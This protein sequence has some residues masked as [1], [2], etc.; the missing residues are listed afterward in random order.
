M[1]KFFLLLG[2]PRCGSSCATACFSF[3][4][5]SLGPGLSLHT[6][7]H[8]EKGYFENDRILN[9]N[10]KV[11]DSLD[12]RWYE[13]ALTPEQVSASFEFRSELMLILA[14]EYTDSVCAV[15][16]MRISLLQDLYLTSFGLSSFLERELKLI[17]INRKKDSVIRSMLKMFPW[18]NEQRATANYDKF[19]QA[20]GLLQEKLPFFN[21]QF[22]ELLADAANVMQKVCDFAEIEFLPEYRSKIVDF[23]DKK[24]VHG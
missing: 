4:N 22:E 7:A 6:D 15:K 11:L 13:N 16:D 8:N 23:I 24:L 19:Y 1:S 14:Q 17:V 2:S 21:L 9:F 20:I 10:R 3:C 5:V 12:L 18:M